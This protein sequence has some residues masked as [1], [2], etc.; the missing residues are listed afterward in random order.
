MLQRS[1][2][3]TLETAMLAEAM[4]EKGTWTA[5]LISCESRLR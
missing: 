2:E 5:G 1:E 3:V 4:L